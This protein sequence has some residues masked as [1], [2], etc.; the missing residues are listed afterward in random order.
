MGQN[1]KAR[2][3]HSLVGQGRT[4]AHKVEQLYKKFETN[5]ASDK[6]TSSPKAGILGP[7]FREGEFDPRFMNHKSQK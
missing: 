7:L 2:P 5:R 6:L 3:L 4:G 1:K